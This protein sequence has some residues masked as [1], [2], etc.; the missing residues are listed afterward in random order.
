[1]LAFAE[2]EGYKLKTA[3]DVT[4]IAEN[5][6]NQ[7]RSKTEEEKFKVDHVRT[8]LGFAK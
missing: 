1:M 7:A 5:E 3:G 8:L 4:H 2:G 6:F